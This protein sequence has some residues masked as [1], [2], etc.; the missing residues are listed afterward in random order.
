[1]KQ[2]L[3][4]LTARFL[5]TPLMI[6]P[7]SLDAL[8]HT[9]GPRLGIDATALPPVNDQA[10]Y[11][12]QIAQAG[13]NYRVIDGVAVI[14]V[15]GPLMKRGSF[16]DTLCGAR[17]YMDIQQDVETAM[18]DPKVKGIMLD[19]SSPGGE[20]T[21]C[22]ECADAIFNARGQKPIYAVAND[23]AA[24]AAYAIASAADQVFVSRTGSVG[25]IGVYALHVDQ[26]EFDKK[27]GVKYTYIHAGDR[28][29][30]GNPHAPL[31]DAAKAEFQEEIDRQYQMF[32]N[33]VARNRKAS[34]DDVIA[35][36]ARLYWSDKSVPLLADSVGTIDDAMA[37]MLTAIGPNVQ[38]I[39]TKPARTLNASGFVVSEAEPVY[40]VHTS[41]AG[42][43]S[44]SI[45][46]PRSVI[47]DDYKA[48][49]PM[50]STTTAGNVSL[51]ISAQERPAQN[52]R[53]ED[54]L[55]NNENTSAASVAIPGILD[56]VATETRSQ[57]DINTIG[58]LCRIA[59]NPGL[60]VDFLTK[61]N[62]SGQYLTVAEVS[63]ELMTARAN[64]AN[65]HSVA[66]Q[67]DVIQR[68]AAGHP[69]VE[70]LESQARSLAS[71]S[72][73]TTSPAL[74][75]A[76]VTRRGTT[77]QQAFAQM[78]EDHPEAYGEYRDRHN[79]QALVTT[80]RRAGYTIQQS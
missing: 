72:R 67:V 66:S 13:G 64:E 44:A 32:T 15:H 41:G 47:V 48:R 34:I 51:T 27:M 3:A 7:A 58:N 29:V 70:Q 46:V 43:Q 56:A 54:N 63:Q 31:S 39:P 20:V 42:F 12:T 19:I 52:E 4:Y 40:L 74:Y 25:S 75:V 45:T 36:Q 53:T 65:R 9:L 23:M 78:L 80:L 59:G 49:H 50:T 71:Q 5:N 24:S 6:H 79:A 17:T 28:K 26:A 21:G 16:M 57:E 22:F 77:P 1:M 33:T 55:M 18:E 73:G 30:D 14:P 68:T 35:T 62:A 76:G 2:T 61:K 60:A 11:G 38:Q 37:S 8:V 10:S 69:T